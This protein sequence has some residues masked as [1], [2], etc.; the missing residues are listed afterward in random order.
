MRQKQ[1]IKDTTINKDC[2]MTLRLTPY[3]QF[4]IDNIS[5]NEG[6]SRTKLMRGILQRFI[7]N[8]YDKQGR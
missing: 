4:E 6:V 2:R 7:D 1:F 8:Y 3:Q 5:R